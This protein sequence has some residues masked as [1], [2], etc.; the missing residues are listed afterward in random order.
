VPAETHSHRVPFEREQLS[1]LVRDRFE[2]L[3]LLDNGTVTDSTTLAEIGADELLLMDL[4][5]SLQE[6]LG[7]RTTTA[8]LGPGQDVELQELETVGDTVDHVRRVFS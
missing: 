6:D 3:L 5:D 8:D 7:E 2:E 4:L 1:R